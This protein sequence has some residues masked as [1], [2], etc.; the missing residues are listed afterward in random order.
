MKQESIEQ[1]GSRAGD[2]LTYGGGAS[3]V[4]GGFSMTDW[5]ALAG[6][7]GMA[8]GLALQAYFGWLRNEREQREH[9]ARMA[10]LGGDE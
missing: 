3:A 10:R 2:T 6:I 4:I 9:A 1:I 8:V 7:I 5:A